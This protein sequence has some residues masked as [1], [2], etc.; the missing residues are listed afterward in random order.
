MPV[1]P[2]YRKLRQEDCYEFG[3]TFDLK[4]SLRIVWDT[5]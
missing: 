4:M 2:A 3:V 5:E 1:I